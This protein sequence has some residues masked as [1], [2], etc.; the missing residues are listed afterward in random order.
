M[1]FPFLP[2]FAL[3]SHRSARPLQSPQPTASENV[4]R[5]RFAATGRIAGDGLINRDCSSI[6]TS[7]C[8]IGR[9]NPATVR[10]I[11]A[12]GK[13]PTTARWLRSRRQMARRS[14]RVNSGLTAGAV[15][16]WQAGGQPRR[17]LRHGQTNALVLRALVPFS[18]FFRRSSFSHYL[19][20][21]SCTRGR[22]TRLEN[23][24]EFGFVLHHLQP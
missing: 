5:G 8:P 2:A 1:L 19:R 4:E 13:E 23:V 15:T 3:S 10:L 12:A 20:G 7:Q 14:A 16:P 17:G 22:P 24:R 11:T 21:L 18:F 6:S 9:T